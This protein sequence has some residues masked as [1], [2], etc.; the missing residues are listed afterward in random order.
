MSGDDTPAYS[1][2]SQTR[3]ET[4]GQRAVARVAQ[5]ADFNV[6]GGT[7]DTEVLTNVDANDRVIEFVSMRLR[8]SFTNLFAVDLVVNAGQ[9]Q[10]SQFNGNTLHFPFA[11]DPGLTWV[12]GEDIVV[13]YANDSQTPVDFALQV[14]YVLLED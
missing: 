13:D 4:Q 11:F 10:Q 14:S 8:S 12:S 7:T 6:G 3:G 2:I 1:P 9:N 5:V